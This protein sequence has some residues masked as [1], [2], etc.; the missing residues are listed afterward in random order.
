MDE[1]LCKIIAEQ[2]ELYAQQSIASHQNLAP[3]S[4]VHSWQDT[5][6]DEVKILIGILLLQEI[7]HKPKH[8]MYFSNRK[9]EQEGKLFCVEKV[10]S[11]AIAG[12]TSTHYLLRNGDANSQTSHLKGYN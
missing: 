7:I 5:T 11:T 6:C 9:Q 4:M 12:G 2:T 1:A 10:C 3:C 8:K